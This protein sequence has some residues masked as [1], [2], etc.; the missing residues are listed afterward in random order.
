MKLA[1]NSFYDILSRV[2]TQLE[3]LQNKQTLQLTRYEHLMDKNLLFWNALSAIQ[4][5]S[6]NKDKQ[7]GDQDSICTET[8]SV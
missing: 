1:Q 6:G 8:K 2:F 4:V 3:T 7:P 5:M